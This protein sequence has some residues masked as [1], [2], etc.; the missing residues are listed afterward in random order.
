MESPEARPQPSMATPTKEDALPK[1]L[2][3]GEWRKVLNGYLA[4]A[5]GQLERDQVFINDLSSSR[6]AR[7]L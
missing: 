5:F 3:R 1:V 2:I 6:V 7:R 4:D